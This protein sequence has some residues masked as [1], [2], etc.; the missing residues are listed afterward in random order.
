[1]F[2]RKMKKFRWIVTIIGVFLLLCSAAVMVILTKNMTKETTVKKPL[3]ALVNED[4]S[5]KFNGR[6]YNFGQSFV[7]LVSN[8]NKYNWQVVSR[9]VA[10][11][12]F[13]DGSVQAVIYMPQDFSSNILTLQAINPQKAEV[14]Y[15]V[16]NSQS[17]LTNKLLQDKIVNVL[18]DFNSSIVK[19]YYAS[20]AGNVASAQT[21]LG[22]VV[23]SQGTLLSNLK[24]NVYGPFQTTNQSYSVVNSYA[25]GLKSQNESWIQAQNSFTKSVTSQLHS[26]S[27]SF[28]NEL[29]NLTTYFDTQKKITDVNLAN[30]NQGIKNQANSDQSDYYK[31][32]TEAYNQAVAMM[33][34]FDNTDDAGNETGHFANLK[35]QIANYN[36]I[37]GG[38]RD[39][40]N[41]QIGQ[42]SD[43]QTTLF[44][45]EK[46]LYSQF[47]AQSD[48]NPTPGHTD[49]TDRQTEDNARTALANLLSSSFSG[50][51]NLA[52]SPYTN[53]LKRLIRQLSM[54]SGQYDPLLTAL[55]NNGSMTSQQKDDI[56]AQLGILQNYAKQYGIAGTDVQLKDAPAANTTDQGFTKTIKITVPAATT[57]HL[58][59]SGDAQL[60]LDPNNAPTGEGIN[61]DNPKDI[62]LDNST[63]PSTDANG[64]TVQKPTTT[65]RDYTVTYIVDL[66][67]STSATVEF[68]WGTTNILGILSQVGSTA[69][70]FSLIPANTISEYAGNKFGYIN[71]LLN[72]IDTASNLIAFLYG[73]P[74]ATFRNMEGVTD[75]EGSADAKSIYKMYGNMDRSQIRERLSDDDVKSYMTNGQKN[76]QEV[77]DTLT[78]LDQTM[79]SLNK[80]QATLSNTMPSGYFNQITTDLTNWYNQTMKS[81][82]DQYQAW[83]PNDT[84]TLQE[85]SWQEYDQ[86]ATAL[87][88]DKKASDDLYGN[89][90]GMVTST[91]KQAKDTADS[92][93]II[94]SNADQF[95]QLVE[96]VTTT[97]NNAKKVIDNTGSLLNSGDGD[98]KNSQGYYGNF[99]NTL[100]NTRTTGADPNHIFDFFAKPLVTKDVT[101]ASKSI[102]QGFDWRWV[103]VF[104][105]GL[106]L[107]V[108][109]TLWARR[110]PKVEA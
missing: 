24:N 59:Y 90:S 80:D 88:Y 67:Q 100:A 37:V 66:G 109:G 2:D 41:G 93:Q 96:N 54:D 42:L 44:D 65:P 36:A 47:F 83:K 38:V 95:N 53:T 57:Y 70:T 92:A 82:N 46:Q 28:S 68:K 73:A 43:K 11:K 98:L 19:M 76:I 16:Q 50:R 39:D 27:Q 4:Q 33:Q 56:D 8:D 60:S 34:Q 22:N 86:N 107:G 31:Q 7:N 85:K 15:K 51:D 99:A 30:A 13:A 58:R 29:P 9:A 75:F 79:D 62:V 108:L 18:Y 72:N 26:T 71:S 52:D 17:Q 63:Y 77:T 74:G 97:Q 1:M 23:N 91:A 49:F 78:T 106:L 104:I 103:L 110:T 14:D 94:K 3:I 5:M 12:A 20:V 81:L 102:A 84:V 105:I 10:N 25:N 32:Y 55:V 6:D 64:N 87:Y 48:V 45:L 35:S 61:V 69:E 101:P 21:N 40:I 89:I